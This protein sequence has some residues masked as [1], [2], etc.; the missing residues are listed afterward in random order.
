MNLIKLLDNQEVDR[1]AG[2]RVK[3]LKKAQLI[4]CDEIGYT[5]ISRAQANRF[6][7]FV[8]DTYSDI[9]D[10]VQS[11][12]KKNGT[13]RKDRNRQHRLH[14]GRISLPPSWQLFH[15]RGRQIRNRTRDD[16]ETDI[17]V[18]CG[19][20]A[21]LTREFPTNSGVG[22]SARP[23]IK[24]AAPKDGLIKKE[25]HSDHAECCGG[26]A[27]ICLLELRF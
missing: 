27:V 11:V 7:T 23:D 22:V 21:P 24:K 26:D 12:L 19:D 8:S 14:Y 9:K 18:F 4:I 3:N 2:F 5:P 15:G 16:A 6:F 20:R 10:I 17:E 13:K 25:Q 1:A